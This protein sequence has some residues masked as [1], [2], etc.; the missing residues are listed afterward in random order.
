MSQYF[1][2]GEY[3][4]YPDKNEVHSAEST[5]KV[6]PKT[7]DLLLALVNA[8]GEI[9][10]KADLLEY[11][12][13]DVVVEEHVI[14]QS[15]TELRK[16]F[17]TIQVIKT[18]PR[19]G[20]SITAE[21]VVCEA[22]TTPKPSAILQHAEQLKNQRKMPLKQVFDPYK[23]SLA[24]GIVFLVI[25]LTAF[26]LMRF[27]HNSSELAVSGSILVLPVNNKIE[28]SSH[29]WL[30]YGG[31]DLLIKSLQP[32]SSHPV[33][34]TEI[35]LDMLK[36][37]EIDVNAISENVIPRLF[38]VS[39]SELIVEQAISGFSGD[40]QL[41][42]SL[43][44]RNDVT[45]G[46]LFGDDINSLY[47]QLNSI[48]LKSLGI[49]ESVSNVIYKHHFTNELM[50]AAIDQV[51][52]ENYEKAAT[53]FRA[54]LVSEPENLLAVKMLA[55]SLVFLGQYEEAESVASDA[56]EFAMKSHDN[57]NLGRLFFWQAVSLTQQHKYKDAL[58]VLDYARAK[59]HN[60]HDVLYLANVARITGKIY[61]LRKQ[62]AQSRKQIDKAIGLYQSIKEPY[63]QASMHIDLGELAL[64]QNQFDQAIGAFN[65][66]RKLAEQ[67]RIQQ[68]IDMANEWLIKTEQAQTKS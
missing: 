32:Y 48:L 46:V 45:R 35:A 2:I 23:K 15:I 52:S 30:N 5:F 50:A 56:V 6:R 67:S 21:I 3:T 43:Y 65:Q 53:L 24:V 7:A 59:S 16:I 40:Y 41:V 44:E 4:F 22:P 39:G 10:S 55:K 8:K 57:K 26:Q 17:N 58:A 34:P 18:H 54:I 47:T 27:T 13:S 36:R 60:T 14:F 33:I 63:G 64:A 51:Q 29:L 61:M 25:V 28:S 31:M 20:Y 19:K 62:Y 1:Q 49:S 9:V 66:A 68:L 37:A 12:W 38:E 42:Y 11:V